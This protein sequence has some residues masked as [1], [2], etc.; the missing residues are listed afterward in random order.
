MF[1]VYKVLGVRARGVRVLSATPGSGQSG[2]RSGPTAGA[3][4][5]W[6]LTMHLAG[7]F[8]VPRLMLP[9]CTGALQEPLETKG[10]SQRGPFSM[11]QVAPWTRPCLASP[12]ASLGTPVDHARAP[13]PRGGEHPQQGNCTLLSSQALLGARERGFPP[14][15]LPEQFALITSLHFILSNQLLTLC[16]SCRAS[17]ALQVKA[18]PS[19]DTQALSSLAL[20]FPLRRHTN[21]ASVGVHE[22]PS[23]E[24]CP[25]CAD[26]RIQQEVLEGA[27]GGKPQCYDEDEG[28]Y[29]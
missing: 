1:V 25:C 2:T 17:D 29:L 4:G 28:G 16:A 23:P 10:R 21:P 7:L 11:V 18:Q 5:R 8:P 9:K 3:E 22:Q 6:D 12:A 13:P 24:V 26:S 27:G 14:R 20:F 19:G 15:T